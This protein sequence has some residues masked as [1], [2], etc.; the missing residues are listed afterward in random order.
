M[1]LLDPNSVA[2]FVL[3]APSPDPNSGVGGGA[4]INIDTQAA[5]G[6]LRPASVAVEILGA[7]SM[8]PH[9]RG[10]W[11]VTEE[12]MARSGR[13]ANDRSLD[14]LR[15]TSLQALVGLR[16]PVV[17]SVLGMTQIDD[18]LYAVEEHITGGVCCVHACACDDPPMMLRLCLARASGGS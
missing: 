6:P 18:V 8:R 1:I 14:L 4:A 3:H 5:N 12:A 2:D 7:G 15:R 13:S 11:A 9:S 10:A 17:V 16:S